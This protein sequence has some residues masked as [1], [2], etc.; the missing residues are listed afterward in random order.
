MEYTSRKRRHNLINF[1]KNLKY[2]AE[3]ISDFHLLKSFRRPKKIGAGAEGDVY[4]TKFTKKVYFTDN[5]VLKAIDLQKKTLD[6]IDDT[7]NLYKQIIENFAL[8]SPVFIELIGQTLTNQLILQNICPHYSMNYYW[9]FT[10]EYLVTTNEYA[11]GKDFHSWAQKVHSPKLWF[12][13]LFQIMTGII[14]MQKYF[15]M[16]HTDLHTQNILVY[17][18]KRGGYWTYT[19]NGFKYYLPNLGYVFLIHDLGF[20]WIPDKMYVDWHYEQT[21]SFVTN[22]G[23]KYYDIAAF[24]GYIN[25]TKSYKTPKKVKNFLN[26]HFTS[27]DFEFIF[28]K[29]YYSSSSEITKINQKLQTY[30]DITIDYSGTGISLMDKLYTMFYETPETSL[31]Q[32]PAGD[33]L[34]A[35]SLDKEFNKSKLPRQFLHLLSK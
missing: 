10:E 13:A 8:T 30:P 3:N 19:I 15:N 25:K 11:N 26:K 9:D 1:M 4:I 24:L 32:R 34:D 6:K 35:Y 18:V 2:Q 7:K 16:T 23:R 29:D 14:A 27:N 20:A 12:N 5:V 28:T 22:H 17:K 31:K 21:L 33:K